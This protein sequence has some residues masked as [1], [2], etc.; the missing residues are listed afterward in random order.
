MY[1]W[2]ARTN[3]TPGDASRVKVPSGGAICELETGFVG[4][5]PVYAWAK[6]LAGRRCTARPKLLAGPR[7]YSP[8][9]H[10]PPDEVERCTAKA[11]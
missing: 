6:L 2:H 7:I 11:S 3:S 9:L 8:K 1:F 10:K 4:W 5:A